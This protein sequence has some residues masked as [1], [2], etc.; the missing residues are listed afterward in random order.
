MKAANK[1][2]PGWRRARGADPSA[3]KLKTVMDFL[4]EKGIPFNYSR[5]DGY[6]RVYFVDVFEAIG[7]EWR[8]REW[9]EIVG[10]LTDLAAEIERKTGWRRDDDVTWQED[11]DGWL[12]WGGE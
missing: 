7:V 10:V 1:H 11:T 3:A 12:F 6:V 8:G 4:E 2:A 5:E 9:D